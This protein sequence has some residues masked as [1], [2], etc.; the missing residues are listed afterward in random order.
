[1]VRLLVTYGADVNLPDA[2]GRPPLWWA[3]FGCGPYGPRFQTV[4][5]LLEN[6]ANGLATYRGK[7]IVA[8]AKELAEGRGAESSR[9]AIWETLQE[10][11]D[12]RDPREGGDY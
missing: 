12:L 2:F 4:N 1:M 11:Y 3:V 8:L 10:K 5:I 6:G 7:S 9:R